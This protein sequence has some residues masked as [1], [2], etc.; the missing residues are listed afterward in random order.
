M[1]ALEKVQ[2]E[3]LTADKIS[4]RLG[5]T[6]LPVSVVEQFMYE[7]FDTPEYAKKEIHV[8]YSKHTSQWN[9]TRKSLDYTNV[10][11][12][13]TYG[14]GRANGYRLLEEALNLRNVRVV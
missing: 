11:A 6:W 10:I 3:D 12:S 8:L 14:T 9:I 1:Q 2:P 5:A 4:V 13:S 7:L